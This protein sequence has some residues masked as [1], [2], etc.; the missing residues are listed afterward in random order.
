MVMNLT[1][2]M[3]KQMKITTFYADNE[4][5]EKWKPKVKELDAS[6]CP[7][8]KTYIIKNQRKRKVYGY[9]KNENK[10]LKHV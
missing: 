8:Y 1:H 5:S 9:A 7:A 2:S 3:D 4:F 6:E 10:K